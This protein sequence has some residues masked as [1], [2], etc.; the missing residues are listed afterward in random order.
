MSIFSYNGTNHNEYINESIIKVLMSASTIQ[1]D[2][3]TNKT[4]LEHVRFEHN[5]SC[6]SILSNA[7]EGC[8]NLTSI[9]IPNSINTIDE[10][11]FTLSGLKFVIISKHNSLGIPVPSSNVNFFGATVTT[12]C[13]LYEKL[14]PQSK[15][16]YRHFRGQKKIVSGLSNIMTK[17]RYIY[18]PSWTTNMTKRS[19]IN[20]GW[21]HNIHRKKKILNNTMVSMLYKNKNRTNPIWSNKM[22]KKIN[23]YAQNN[24][25]SGIKQKHITGISNTNFKPILKFKS[26]NPYVKLRIKHNF[27][28]RN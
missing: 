28:K 1:M 15:H 20:Y 18:N 27:S 26:K 19:G 17:K 5:S 10:S 24:K 13:P 4:T 2:A 7:F 11:V 6:T 14:S 9:N 16:V 3:F 23:N 12:K 22:T 25:L 21:N 8:N